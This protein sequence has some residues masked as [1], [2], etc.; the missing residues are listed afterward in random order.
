MDD[1][2]IPLT[3]FTTPLGL[4]EYTRMPFGLVNAPSCF[5]R[6]MDYTLQGLINN[7]CYCYLDDIIIFSKTFSDHLQDLEQVLQRIQQAN[8]RLKAK[9]CKFLKHQV[10]YLGHV[11]TKDGILPEPE[12]IR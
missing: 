8:L 5:Q 12:K 6:M 3:A 7:T 2:S 11:I 10:T 9:K 4:F 1:N